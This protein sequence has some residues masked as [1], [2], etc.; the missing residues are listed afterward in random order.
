M[1][2]RAGWRAWSGGWKTGEPPADWWLSTDGRWYPPGVHRPPGG[3]R[4]RGSAAEYRPREFAEAGAS[5]AGGVGV[6]TRAHPSPS[7]MADLAPRHAAHRRH[8]SGSARAELGSL[9]NTTLVVLIAA[10]AAVIAAIL[11]G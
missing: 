1:E 6:V 9:F 3:P 10:L 2:Q 4:W 8:P 11:V 5:T 7:S